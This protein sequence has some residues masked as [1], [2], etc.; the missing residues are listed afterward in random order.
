A[1]DE[2][3]ATAIVFGAIRSDGTVQ[4]TVTRTQ[5]GL[6]GTTLITASCSESHNGT[7]YI[8]NIC[9]S[10]VGGGNEPANTGISADNDIDIYIARAA[11]LELL[12]A[13]A[14]SNQAI[15]VVDLP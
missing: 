8:A 2:A 11:L 12:R 6:I 9:A 5:S 10:F 3:G 13:D 7:V 14:A 1:G 15:S 4:V